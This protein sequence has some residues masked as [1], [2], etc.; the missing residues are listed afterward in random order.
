P[1]F[2]AL[3]VAFPVEVGPY[4]ALLRL[5][6]ATVLDAFRW[7]LE[8]EARRR[9]L[10]GTAEQHPPSRECQERAVLRASDADI[11]EAALFLD[12]VLV[13]ERARMGEHAVLHAGEEDDRELEALH[14]MQRDERR[15]GLGLG[16]LVLVRDERDLFEERGQL[17]LLREREELLGEAAQ[18]EHVRVSL[19]PFLGAVL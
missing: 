11:G 1:L 9:V 10:V 5:D 4:V 2:V 16:E 19:L 17:L 8:Q 3:A 12:A 13:V 7:E 6:A 14:R 18:L 15:D